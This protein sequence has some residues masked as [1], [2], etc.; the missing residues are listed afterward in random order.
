[1]VSELSLASNKMARESKNET[2]NMQGQH[3]S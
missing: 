3:G 2:H 1:M